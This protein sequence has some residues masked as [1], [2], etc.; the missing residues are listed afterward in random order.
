MVAAA[1]RA[2]PAVADAPTAAAREN[3]RDLH[4]VQSLQHFLVTPTDAD[5]AL[6]ETST[7]QE[8]RAAAFVVMEMWSNCAAEWKYDDGQGMTR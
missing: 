4:G 1:R 8:R 5:R 6:L 2:W 7:V 3:G